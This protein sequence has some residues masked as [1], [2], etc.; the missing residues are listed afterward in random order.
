M[1]EMVQDVSPLGR[2]QAYLRIASAEGRDVERIGPFQASFS[3]SSTNPFVNYAIPDDGASPSSDDVRSLVE[4]YRKRDRRPRLEYCANLAPGVE[5]ALI[6]AGFQP[7]MRTPLMVCA[8]GA[9]RKVRVPDG[10][11]IFSPNLDEDLGALGRAQSQ[12]FGEP[13][14]PVDQEARR[15]RESLD[16]G[17]K[18]LA[19]RF[20][21]GPCIGGG[22]CTTPAH[23][24]TEV[25]GIGVLQEFRRR[26][27]ATALTYALA[28]LAFESGV[29]IAFL[30]AGHDEGARVYSRVGF[31]TVGEV[32]HISL[33]ATAASA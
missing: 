14:P 11:E 21:G 31:E 33:P 18:M 28:E 32:L 24:L 7:E 3:R 23:G 26:G 19:A 13:P 8:K 5:G 20:S 17:D 15:L 6:S 30:M 4:A 29:E 12:A 16:R 22:V 1:L 9:H 27:V 10:L 25:A 2:I